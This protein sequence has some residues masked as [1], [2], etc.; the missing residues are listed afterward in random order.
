[1]CSRVD[2]SKVKD[3]KGSV[4]SRSGS[5]GESGGLDHLWEFQWG[6]VG[7]RVCVMGIDSPFGWR[8]GSGGGIMLFELLDGHI[9]QKFVDVGR[10]K[11]GSRRPSGG[12]SA[13]GRGS[14]RFPRGNGGD[15][16]RPSEVVS[17][18]CCVVDSFFLLLLVLVV[19][20]FF[21]LLLLFWFHFC[22]CVVC[23]V[24]WMVQIY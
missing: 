16:R 2:S 23:I 24:V 10:K 8:V 4:L 22:C 20:F 13:S 1:M 14:G 15:I 21:W 12:L 17:C 7:V 3:S 18:D 5:A 19:S 11:D 6:M 9:T